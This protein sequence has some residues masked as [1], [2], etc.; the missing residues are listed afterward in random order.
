MR[1]DAREISFK[2]VFEYLFKNEKNIDLQAELAVSSECKLSEDDLKLIDSTYAGVVE[3]S[4][5][6]QDAIRGLAVGFTLERMYKTDVALL[7]VAIYEIKYC[8]DIPNV[9]SVN[10]AL[11][12]SKKYSSEKSTSFINGILANYMKGGNAE[13][14][15]TEV[16][17]TEEVASEEVASEEVVETAE[18]AV[19]TV[20][21]VE[22]ITTETEV[23]EEVATENEEKN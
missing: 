12:L 21:A 15:A 4:E 19:E 17:T 16:V 13:V 18:I 6:L 22:E 8:D 9:V 14:V 10:E 5:E 11:E 1:R 20:E 23:I 7:M 3:H 2:L